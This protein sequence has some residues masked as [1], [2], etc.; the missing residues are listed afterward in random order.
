MIL[1]VLFRFWLKFRSNRSLP[2]ILKALI[3]HYQPMSQNYVRLKRS[4][5]NV[6]SL[7]THKLVKKKSNLTAEMYAIITYAYTFRLT[8]CI[9]SVIKLILF[10]EITVIVK[11]PSSAHRIAAS[12]YEIKFFNV[13]FL[14]II[15]FIFVLCRIYSKFIVCMFNC[16]KLTLY[17][18]LLHPH[19]N[20]GIC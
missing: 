17:V 20:N 1:T 10:Y 13:I 2:Y 14:T 18:E 5:F 16:N 4:V 12:L 8:N 9:L 3:T 6:F 11:N 7:S 15:K 19:N